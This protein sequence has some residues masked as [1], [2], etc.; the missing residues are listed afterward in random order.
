MKW[1]SAHRII[2]Y[3]RL[4]GTHRDHQVWLHA[5]RRTT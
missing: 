1:G 3:F 4:E 2:E 5:P